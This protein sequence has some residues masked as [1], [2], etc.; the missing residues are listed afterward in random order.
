MIKYSYDFSGNVAV[1]GES[2]L[3]AP[4]ITGQPV[5]QVAAPGD[6]VTF[7]VVVSDTSGVT[8]QWKFNGADIP[9]AMGDGLLLTN[10]STVNVG[11]YSV[12]VTNSVGSVKSA[13]EAL[14]LED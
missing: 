8:F 11:Q 2:A 5:K 7:S 1:R 12:V 14:M 9:G 3:L 6:I 4:Q 13:P 10:V